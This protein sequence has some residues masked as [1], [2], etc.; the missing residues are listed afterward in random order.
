[1]RQVPYFAG[2]KTTEHVNLAIVFGESEM[3]S[4]Q[5]HGLLLCPLIYG[6]VILIDHSDRLPHGRGN[7]SRKDVHFAVGRLSDD[8]LM[9]FGKR[10]QI[11]PLSLGKS[12]GK[13]QT[14]KNRQR[15]QGSARWTNTLRHSVRSIVPVHSVEV[16]PL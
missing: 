1:R 10:R 2:R 11:H 15:T 14:E 7:E 8:L 12:S 3:V 5:R 4:R 9:R 16:F 13:T 6:R